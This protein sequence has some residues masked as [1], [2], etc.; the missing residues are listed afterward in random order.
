MYDILSRSSYTSSGLS[1]RVFLPLVRDAELGKTLSGLSA[2][3]W[4]G[5][6]PGVLCTVGSKRLLIFGGGARGGPIDLV[7]STEFPSV[8]GAEHC[9]AAATAALRRSGELCPCCR[10]LSGIRD[11]IFEGDLAAIDGALDTTEGGASRRLAGRMLVG[12]FVVGAAFRRVAVPTTL[13]GLGG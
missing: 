12:V 11:G 6:P 7:D 9:G 8:R 4:T 2:C 3:G 1:G 5:R 10:W 13:F